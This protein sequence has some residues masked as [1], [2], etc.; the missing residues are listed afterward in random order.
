MI[1]S[2]SSCAAKANEP[3]AIEDDERTTLYQVLLSLPRHTAVH[4]FFILGVFVAVN[5]EQ[6]FFFGVDEGYGHDGPVD[7]WENQHSIRCAT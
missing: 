2:P 5:V 3:E 4:V 6:P 1:E 7:K